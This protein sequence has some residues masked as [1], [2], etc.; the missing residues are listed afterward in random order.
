MCKQAAE[1]RRGNPFYE[2]GKNGMKERHRVFSINTGDSSG[3]SSSAALTF[4]SDDRQREGGG[5]VNDL[6]HR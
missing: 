5:G 4:G 1:S 6:L 2:E 3:I